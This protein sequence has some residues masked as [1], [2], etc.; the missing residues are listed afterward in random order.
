MDAARGLWVGPQASTRRMRHLCNVRTWAGCSWGRHE[1]RQSLGKD[2]KLYNAFN[3]VVLTSGYAGG[4]G[5]GKWR[6]GGGVQQIL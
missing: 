3:N 6:G 5:N 2:F 1:V 4:L